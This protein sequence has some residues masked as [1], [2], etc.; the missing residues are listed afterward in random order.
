MEIAFGVS[1][2]SISRFRIAADSSPA[3]VGPL[4]GG[5]L[6]FSG[7]SRRLMLIAKRVRPHQAGGAWRRPL[8]LAL[9]LSADPRIWP[10]PVRPR[11][12]AAARARRPERCESPNR[13][14]SPG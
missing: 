3:L 14:T 8:A 4:P 7:R 13:R 9:A 6:P 11:A 12:R 10:T 5:G 1:R 2:D